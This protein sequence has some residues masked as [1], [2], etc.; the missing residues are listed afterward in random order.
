MQRNLVI[1]NRVLIDNIIF[2]ILLLS[3]TIDS[4]NGVFV[5]MGALSIGQPIRIILFFFIIFRV[6]SLSWKLFG[7]LL[8][9]YCLLMFS[10]FIH[11]YNYYNLSWF[12][13]DI[14]TI[15]KFVLMMAVWF[16]IHLVIK[17]QL[18][19][20]SFF[21]WFYGFNLIVLIVNLVLGVFGIGYA[22][23]SGGIGSVGFFY[24]GNE[25]SGVMICLF[26]P[27]LFYVYYKKS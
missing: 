15:H 9:V 6:L 14:A 22:Q 27:I 26:M 1:L 13:I 8:F 23:Y 19:S 18:V 2:L 7:V 4:V 16:Y 12:V 10:S 17:Y 20:I 21:K 24:A 5:R 11:F 25:V 3:L